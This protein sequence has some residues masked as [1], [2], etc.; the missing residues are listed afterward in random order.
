MCG[1]AARLVVAVGRAQLSDTKHF[2][3]TQLDEILHAYKLAPTNGAIS[4]VRAAFCNHV[5]VRMHSGKRGALELVIFQAASEG[6][7]LAVTEPG[8]TVSLFFQ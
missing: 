7:S 3:R 6:A 8:C 4:S 1:Q 2:Q 5:H